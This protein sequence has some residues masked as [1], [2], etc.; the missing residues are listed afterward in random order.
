MQIASFRFYL[1][2]VVGPQKTEKAVWERDYQLTLL[3]LHARDYARVGIAVWRIVD[4]LEVLKTSASY[5]L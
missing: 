4:P 5:I 2:M 1:C 3:W